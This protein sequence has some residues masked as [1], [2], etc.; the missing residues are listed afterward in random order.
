MVVLGNHSGR[1]THHLENSHE[2]Y[3]N[4]MLNIKTGLGMYIFQMGKGQGHHEGQDHL[5]SM[6]PVWQYK[7]KEQQ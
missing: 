5:K 6:S 7:K 3:E 4:I 1:C 2:N